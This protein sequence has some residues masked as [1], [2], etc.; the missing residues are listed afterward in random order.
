M[1]YAA[2]VDRSVH[3][4]GD[5]T[6]SAGRCGMQNLKVDESVEPGCLTLIPE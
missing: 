3:A 2:F 1:S 6:R 4:E 5:R